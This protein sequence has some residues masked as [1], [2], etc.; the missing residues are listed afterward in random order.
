MH[1]HVLFVEF[2]HFII[3]LFI[4]Y[5]E[6]SLLKFG[7]GDFFFTCWNHRIVLQRIKIIFMYSFKFSHYSKMCCY[8]CLCE[9]YCKIFIFGLNI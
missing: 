7:G 8:D 1:W 5:K 9:F 6:L 3:K 2:D 4:I